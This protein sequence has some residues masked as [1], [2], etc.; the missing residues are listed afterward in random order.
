MALSPI[1]ELCAA[2]ERIHGTEDWGAVRGLLQQYLA[3]G[4]QR[5]VATQ[6]PPPK[7][8]ESER[9]KTSVYRSADDRPESDQWKEVTVEELNATLDDIEELPLDTS[10]TSTSLPGKL[11]GEVIT[12]LPVEAAQELDASPPEEP[13]EMGGIPLPEEPVEEVEASRPKELAEG[14]VNRTTGKLVWADESEESSGPNDSGTQKNLSEAAEPMETAGSISKAVPRKDVDP[15]GEAGSS[16]T[17]EKIVAAKGNGTAGPTE[18]AKIA[19]ADTITADAGSEPHPEEQISQAETGNDFA[20]VHR[21]GLARLRLERA[22]A[23]MLTTTA[24]ATEVDKAT[25]T[26]TPAAPK[27]NI[28]EAA[29]RPEGA[30]PVWVYSRGSSKPTLEWFIPDPPEERKKGS[31]Q[32]G[33]KT[34]RQGTRSPGPAVKQ[35]MPG[36]KQSEEE[37]RA[38]QD[39]CWSCGSKDHRQRDCR[40]PRGDYCYRCG[41]Q[42]VTVKTCPLC[43]PRWKAGGP[44]NPW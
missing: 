26:P 39:G 44:H 38:R 5:T 28:D 21:H 35:R 31:P 16:V 6:T 29:G 19:T 9:T 22:R 42:G 23:S 7:L 40:T 13:T 34:S 37:L 12:S 2:L 27:A 3:K 18:G 14:V 36:Q 41:R 24:E 33:R 11:A 10:I 32:P 17:A 25:A 43:G 4:Q 20:W 15:Q 30:T 1:G 8:P